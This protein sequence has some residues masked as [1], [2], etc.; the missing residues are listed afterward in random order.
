MCEILFKSKTFYQVVPKYRIH[1]G[2]VVLDTDRPVASVV[3]N[4]KL[5]SWF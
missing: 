2:Q 4:W 5:R 1:S 3:A